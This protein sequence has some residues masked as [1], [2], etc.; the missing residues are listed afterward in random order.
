MAIVDEAA[1]AA[2]RDEEPFRRGWARGVDGD[3]EGEIEAGSFYLVD[4]GFHDDGGERM[5][6]VWRRAQGRL[7]V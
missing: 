7:A 1:L 5:L 4:K 2:F 6:V 3:A